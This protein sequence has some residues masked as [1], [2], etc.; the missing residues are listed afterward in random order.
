MCGG[1]GEQRLGTVT[2]LSGT[3]GLTFLKDTTRVLEAPP[4]AP[5]V[6]GQS[7]KPP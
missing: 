7:H 5:L 2:F 6:Y 4:L 3:L 1:G